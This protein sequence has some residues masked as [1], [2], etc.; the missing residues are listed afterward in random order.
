M[1]KTSDVA[2]AVSNGR[3]NFVQ[4]YPTNTPSSIEAIIEN[5]SVDMWEDRLVD[6]EKTQHVGSARR[7][8]GHTSRDHKTLA[9][10]REFL[11]RRDINRMFYKIAKIRDVM[12]MDR[13][14]SPGEHQSSRRLQL[15]CQP[16]NRR[17]RPD[18]RR[19]ECRRA[20]C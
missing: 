18:P 19:P 17:G 15:G 5:T 13:M 2:N 1:L 7:P 11:S 14:N 16:H 9:Y 12:R 3:P 10:D 8:K 6:P 4:A 20:R